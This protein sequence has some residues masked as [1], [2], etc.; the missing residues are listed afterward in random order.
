VPK[1]FRIWLVNGQP[2]NNPLYNNQLVFNMPVPTTSD[3]QSTTM[4]KKA[5]QHQQLQPNK[6]QTITQTKNKTQNTNK[7]PSCTHKTYN[8]NQIKKK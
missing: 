7:K 3:F 8:N 1:D 6:S 4:L 5:S 2:L